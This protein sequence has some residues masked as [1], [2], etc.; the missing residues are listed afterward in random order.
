DATME[1]TRARSAPT[2]PCPSGCT[3]F[4]RKMTQTPVSGSTQIDVPVNPVWPNEP[5]G[6]STPQ[7]DEYALSRS[8]P[9]PRLAP[10]TSAADLVIV[11][12]VS[13]DRMRTPFHV[14][15]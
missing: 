9:R 1:A 15:P 6:S 10:P 14:P 13:G 7:I 5:T 12:T 4:D 2:S 8:Q 11:A 3:Q